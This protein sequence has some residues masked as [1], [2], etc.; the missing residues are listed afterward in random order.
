MPNDFDFNLWL[1]DYQWEQYKSAKRR[2]EW[3]MYADIISGA[4]ATLGG[5]LSSYSQKGYVDVTQLGKGISGVV[6]DIG[7]YAGFAGYTYIPAE[8][9]AYMRALQAGGTAAPV[10]T[11][12]PGVTIPAAAVTPTGALAGLDLTTIAL[13]A[14][15]GILA[16]KVF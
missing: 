12:T 8:A 3:D 4:T 9:M 11:T 5:A 7:E 1:Q 16:F 10:T 15:V 14:I 6:G 13:F 2:A